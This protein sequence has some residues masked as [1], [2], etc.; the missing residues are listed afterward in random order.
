MYRLDRVYLKR[1][2]SRRVSRTL[3]TGLVWG[4]HVCGVMSTVSTGS[5]ATAAAAEWCGS[6]SAPAA[7]HHTDAGS[8]GT[9]TAVSANS[10]TATTT[11]TTATTRASTFCKIICRATRTCWLRV[12]MYIGDFKQLVIDEYV[13]IF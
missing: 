12:Y 4:I 7:G 3:D 2:V 11:T 13:H 1:C 5:S 9:R 6:V 8:T 10:T